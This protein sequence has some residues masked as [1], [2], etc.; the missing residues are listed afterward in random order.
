[1]CEFDALP[2]IGHACGHNLIAEVG[3]ACAVAVKNVMEKSNIFGK[4]KIKRPK[5]YYS[6]RI[7]DLFNTFA[8]HNSRYSSRRNRRWENPSVTSWSF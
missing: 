6:S 2:L 4:V 3:V 8:G 1:M 5:L 7:K